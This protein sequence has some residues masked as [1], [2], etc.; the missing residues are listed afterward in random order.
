[1]ANVWLPNWLS[2]VS[3]V[4]FNTRMAVMTTMME[5]T[6]INTPSRVSADRSLCAVSAFMA[7]EKLSRTSASSKAAMTMLW[8]DIAHGINPNDK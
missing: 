3:A 1:M 7:M 6:P 8:G 4:R 2:P 5:N